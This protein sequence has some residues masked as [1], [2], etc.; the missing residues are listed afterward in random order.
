MSE[1]LRAFEG[2]ACK[3]DETGLQSALAFVD[4]G[5][6]VSMR[7]TADE[8]LP[9]KELCQSSDATDDPR[10]V[11]EDNRVRGAESCS[12]CRLDDGCKLEVLASGCCDEE[13]KYCDR[14]IVAVRK[15]TGA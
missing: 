6:E 7:P 8:S 14:A 3:D 13:A 1:S 9:V 10:D 4:A 11:V 15:G 12:R 5:V 2:K